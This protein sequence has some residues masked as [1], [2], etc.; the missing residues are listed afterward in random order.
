MTALRKTSALEWIFL[1]LALG[2]GA[3]VN[4][5]GLGRSSLWSDEAIYA[6]AAHNA[7]ANGNWYPLK[8]QGRR[9]SWKP[10]LAV[11]PVAVSF[12]AFGESEFSDRLPSAVFA[13]LTVAMVFI[14]SAWM[15]DVWS[16]LFAALLLATIS[17]WLDIH[18]ARAGVTEPLL[19][20]CLICALASYHLYRIEHARR[21]LVVACGAACLSGLYKGLLGPTLLF[22]ATLAD[23]L[24]G[25]VCSMKKSGESRSAP[26]DSWASCFKA[27]SLLLLSGLSAYLLWV[28]ENLLHAPGFLHQLFRD[29]VVRMTSGV[30]AGHLQ[31]HVYY[32]QLLYRGMGYL[33]VP[34]AIGTV[35]ALTT[36]QGARGQALRLTAVFAIVA[37]ALI[38]CSVSK[39]P[40]YITPA[41]PALAVL[42]AAGVR[43]II[44]RPVSV[45]W[46]H[47]SAYALFGLVVLVPRISAAWAIANKPPVTIDMQRIARVIRNTPE[48][49]FHLDIP[50]EHHPIAAG[51]WN[52]KVREW[53]E[54]YLLQ[55]EAVA[56]PLPADFQSSG[57]D[58]VLTDQ[59]P[60]L[61]SRPAF[62]G[63]EVF[64][65]RK[66]EPRESDLAVLDLCKG[67]IRSQLQSG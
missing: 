33:W 1:L 36:G 13:T 48:A 44:F 62:A 49:R 59:A 57:C 31:G 6:V 54:Y 24:T 14:V 52:W 25:F 8:F 18:G 67:R 46:M 42:V 32:L 37:M 28:I 12:A 35:V 56:V 16:G 26:L 23:E 17:P 30:D 27:P 50:S 66:Y 4:F 20:F 41:L 9:Y 5:V 61:I 43:W 10:P 3:A 7:V 63:A 11:W 2:V 29:V 64:K 34:L 47:A 22:L 51:D 19:C 40:W 38:H 53:N 55:T 39:L 58:V 45:Q 15:L 21:W 60:D 65:L